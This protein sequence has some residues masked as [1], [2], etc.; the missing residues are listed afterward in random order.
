M[1][2]AFSCLLTL[3][4]LACFALTVPKHYRQAFGRAGAARTAFLLRTAGVVL[5]AAAPAPW[6]AQEGAA[7]GL[8]VWIFC[9]TPVAGLAAVGLF[10]WLGERR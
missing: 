2:V 6:I 3:A 1:G 9:G 5:L 8:V 10:T 7:M 4:A